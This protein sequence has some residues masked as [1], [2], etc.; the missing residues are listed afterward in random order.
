VCF[1]GGSDAKAKYCLLANVHFDDFIDFGF[2]DLVTW[3]HPRTTAALTAIMSELAKSLVAL[4]TANLA[5]LSDSIVRYLH[6]LLHLQVVGLAFLASTLV[7]FAFTSQ[8]LLLLGIVGDQ[9]I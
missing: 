8:E 5:V 7:H 1:C 6:P 3:I 2:V 4:W 9:V